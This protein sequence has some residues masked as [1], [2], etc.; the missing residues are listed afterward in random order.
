MLAPVELR[1]PDELE[2]VFAAMAHERP[3]A[4]LVLGQPFMFGQGAR[5][6]AL[7]LAQQLP[8]IIPFKEVADAGLL[9]SYGSRVIDDV[10]RLPHY[11]DRIL[12]GTPPGELPVEQTT[13]FYLTINLKTARVLGVSIPPTMLLR[14]DEVVQ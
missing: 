7:A 2:G 4:M 5:L 6:A 3:D 10:R 11:L 9:M 12:K 13:R 14:A 1:A 8:A